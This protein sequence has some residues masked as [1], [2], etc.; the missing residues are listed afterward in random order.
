MST[1]TLDAVVERGH[2]PEPGRLVDVL[3]ERVP[4]PIDELELAAV[5][6]SVGVTDQVAE[7]DYG[8]EDV[9][10][11]ARELYPEVRKLAREPA[12]HGEPLRRRA[13]SPRAGLLLPLVPLVVLAFVLDRLHAAGASSGELTAVALGAGTGALAVNALLLP[14]T[15]RAAVYMGNEQHALAVHFVARAAAALTVV[16][17]LGAAVLAA[18]LA[19]V[20]AGTDAERAGFVIAAGGLAVL[21]VATTAGLLA[22]GIGWVLAAFAAGAA[23]GLL[24]AVAGVA[25]ALPDAVAA[26]ATT[27]AVLV[28]CLA[29]AV[30]GSPVS[31]R[32]AWGWAHL[33]DAAPTAAYGVLASSFLGFASL[34]VWS[35]LY[36]RP[37]VATAIVLL[38]VLPVALAGE[39]GER[40]MWKLWRQ[41]DLAL[42]TA[43]DTG[44]LA[45]HGLA[46]QR[47]ATQAYAL[48]LC[49]IAVG[50]AVVFEAATVLGAGTDEADVQ[51]VFLLA[52]SGFVL[53][54]IGHFQ[55]LFLLS[56]R[57]ASPAADAVAAGLLA[58]AA[59]A[60]AFA[61]VYG[62]A[63][64]VALP[65][66]GFVFVLVCRAAVASTVSELDR[67]LAG[68]F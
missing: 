28:A 21:L 39:F 18:V 54:G 33:R 13:S 11:L 64:V 65:V 36:E 61:P 1:A 49:A 29:I 30:R 4:L 43:D 62:T 46:L 14:M 19:S 16:I 31:L 6:E 9:F 27:L 7:Q 38:S 44:E 42:A 20:S 60:L 12:T 25:S 63:G 26:Y 15:Q 22:C 53:F 24:V 52:L 23:V 5:L 56:L 58:L 10:D 17:L 57:R 41:L 50:E 47:Q 35:G 34:V 59:A 55:A 68:A 8:A 2:E 45:R 66:G 3:A 67:H 40:A 48:A 51:A 32:P 37:L